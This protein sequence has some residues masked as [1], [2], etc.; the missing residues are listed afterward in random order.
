MGHN[1]GEENFLTQE[2]PRYILENVKEVHCF[3][4]RFVRSILERRADC[5]GAKEMLLLRER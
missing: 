2:T 5:T 3:D 1:A 4:A